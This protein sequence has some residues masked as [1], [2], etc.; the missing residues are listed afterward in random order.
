MDKLKF[1]SILLMLGFK[2]VENKAFVYPKYLLCAIVYDNAV[3]IA[4]M[5]EYETSK[6]RNLRPGDTISM[7]IPNDIR[8]TFTHGLELINE[9]IKQ[10]KV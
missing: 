10:T 3:N 5:S 4:H 9:H 1:E 8:Y 2:E 6:V 7:N